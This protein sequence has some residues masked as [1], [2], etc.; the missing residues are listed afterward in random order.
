MEIQKDN[1][2]I[3]NTWG[4]KVQ[5]KRVYSE[6]AQKVSSCAVFFNSLILLNIYFLPFIQEKFLR[7]HAKSAAPLHPFN[8]KFFI[9]NKL[10]GVQS[11]VQQGAMGCKGGA[12]EHP[13]RALH[14]DLNRLPSRVYPQMVQGCKV[15]KGVITVFLPEILLITWKKNTL[16]ILNYFI[17][18]IYGLFRIVKGL[19]Y[20]RLCLCQPFL[21]M[22]LTR[23]T[24]GRNQ[25]AGFTAYNYKLCDKRLLRSPIFNPLGR[26][27]NKKTAIK[28]R[29]TLFLGICSVLRYPPPRERKRFFPDSSPPLPFINC[30][31][32]QNPFLLSGSFL[33]SQEKGG[34]GGL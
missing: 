34:L 16:F 2:S 15:K 10:S 19:C 32:F 9:I 4:A 8:L 22:W 18:L 27:V 6:S 30:S 3:T 7:Q 11:R 33:V 17:V 26:S 31:I 20:P 12:I 28:F 5:P 25:R 23:Q 21:V 13:L 14:P 1:H 29:L 24:K